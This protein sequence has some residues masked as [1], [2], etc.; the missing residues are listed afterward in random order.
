MSREFA[1]ERDA[2][3]GQVG[4]KEE[5]MRL[6]IQGLRHLIKLKNKEL[7]TLKRLSYTILSQRS[8]V[9]QFFHEA[10]SQVKNEI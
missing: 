3:E 7:K 9:E 4:E 8:E 1:Q 2:V 10:L 6:E 5:E